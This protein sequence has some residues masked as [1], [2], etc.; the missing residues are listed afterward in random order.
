VGRISTA[1][2]PEKLAHALCL[3][4]QHCRLFLFGQKIFKVQQFSL[5][6]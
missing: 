3:S 5:I 6:D 4:A 2:P 1:H